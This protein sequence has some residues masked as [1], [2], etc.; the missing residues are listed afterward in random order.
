MLCG[1]EQGQQFL[2]SKF[3]RTTSRLEVGLQ[4]FGGDSSSDQLLYGS[5]MYLACSLPPDFSWPDRDPD[6]RC[7]VVDLL[8]IIAPGE[9]DAFNVEDVFVTPKRLPWDYRQQDNYGWATQ[10]TTDQR[11]LLSDIVALDRFYRTEA[12][13]HGYP[14][15]MMARS[16]KT[17][18]VSLIPEDM[19]ERVAV[20]NALGH[21][22]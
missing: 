11:C 17:L 2:F 5:H 9:T 3:H 8:R 4:D 18:F 16:A 13:P 1:W 6:T 22:V 19:P 10:L 20:L 14:E 12:Y 21:H 7:V 15:G